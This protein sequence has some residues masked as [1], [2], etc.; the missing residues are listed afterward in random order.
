MLRSMRDGAKSGVMKFVLMGLLVLAAAGLVLTDV[1]GFFR[2]GVAATD[3][4]KGKGF[5]IGAQEFDRTV[6]RTLAQQG[7]A[8]QQAYQFGLV[9][10]ILSREIQTRMLSLEAQKHGLMI[11][12]EDL[13][14]EISELTDSIV[15]E[16]ESKKEALQQIL[17]AQGIS[18][19]EFIQSIRN[20][21]RNNI[22]RGALISGTG[23]VS[24]ATGRDLYQ[25]ENQTRDIQFFELTL[26][27]VPD[28]EQPTEIQLEN[29]F[30]TIKNQFL[31]PERRSFTIATLKEAVLENAI[32]I[33]EDSIR[34]L[35]DDQ[36]DRFKK[37]EIRKVNQAIT[38][39]LD[40]ADKIAELAKKGSG[41][42][43]A[44]QKVTGKK[45]A[46]MGESDFEQNGLL[47]EVAEPVF[48]AASGDVVGPIKTALGYHI[49]KINAVIPART[50]PFDEVKTDI[51]KEIMQTRMM[52][53]MMDAANVIDDRLASGEE[54]ESIVS[55]IGLTVEKF[56][57]ITLGGLSK[58]GKEALKSY[59]GDRAAIL[60]AAFTYDT[61]ESSPVMEMGDGRYITVRVDAITE[62]S[63]EPYE[64][65]KE[66]VKAQWI[67]QQRDA[68]N[69]LRLSEA[70]NTLNE[71]KDFEAVAKQYGATIKKQTG[72][73]RLGDI[74]DIK[75]SDLINMIFDSNKGEYVSAKTTDGQVI[76]VVTAI[77]LPD[78][79]KATEEEL[80]VVKA[81]AQNAQSQDIVAQYINALNDE[82][83]VKINERLLD[84][85]YATPIDQ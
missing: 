56:D 79:S 24:D 10:Q 37:N 20:E 41:I 14:A 28:I 19:G 74:K 17:R 78:P 71:T 1:G 7:I 38:S 25:Y 26:K 69:R 16:G 3:V 43:T 18:E 39:N 4:A 2:G 58:D 45:D 51:K 44:V 83:N 22:F 67:E 63:F 55:D 57:S 46:F 23:Y 61:G 52:N 47:A 27:S 21:V 30:E 77:T 73:K 64:D 11:S 32:D 40:E 33:S 31:I 29:Y 68:A 75:S 81:R 6:R 72:I 76:G 84:Q 34:A 15:A 8:P 36:I 48:A 80:S 65:K 53:E 50:Q 60:E 62:R 70:L 82:Y 59:E 9:D 66:M 13:I 49:I 35:Y 85:L 12:D 5:T 54:L 42:Q